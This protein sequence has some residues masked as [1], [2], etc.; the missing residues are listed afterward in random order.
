MNADE[1]RDY[2]LGF[3][4]YKYLSD[5]LHQYVN[6]ILSEDGIAF[7]TIDENSEEGKDVQVHF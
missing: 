1:F 4:F 2:C 6:G 7:T 5:K 3:V